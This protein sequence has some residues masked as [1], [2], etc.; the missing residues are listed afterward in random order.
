MQV[1]IP[2]ACERARQSLP[3]DLRSASGRVAHSD[4]MMQ[5]STCPYIAFL[6]E[7]VKSSRESNW[8]ESTRK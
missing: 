3:S 5:R 6:H 8:N 7:I 4:S 1:H 2:V